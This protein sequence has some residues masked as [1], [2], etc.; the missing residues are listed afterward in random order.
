MV[1][2]NY[3]RKHLGER[4]DSVAE[5]TFGTERQANGRVAPMSAYRPIPIERAPL[6][7]LVTRADLRRLDPDT[8]L[9]LLAA[10]LDDARQD[11]VPHARAL[12]R[13]N[14][15]AMVD[16]ALAFRDELQ[17]AASGQ[18]RPHLSDATSG[19]STP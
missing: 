12:Y 6:I 10:L 17:R 18:T 3:Q 19:S 1:V 4:A 13:P 5:G 16:A 2:G 15:D 9:S 14:V 11:L 8:R 7:I